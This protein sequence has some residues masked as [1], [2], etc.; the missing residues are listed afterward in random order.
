MIN[1]ANLK[2]N[3]FPTISLRIQYVGPSPAASVCHA[4][5]PQSARCRRLHISTRTTG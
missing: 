5:E 4:T 2:T 3:R 1:Y